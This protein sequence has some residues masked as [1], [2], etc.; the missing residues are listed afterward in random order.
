MDQMEVLAAAR[1]LRRDFSRHPEI[2]V[3]TDWILGGGRP[4]LV[5]AVSEVRE[6]IKE[7]IIEVG[8]GECLVC[9]ARREKERLRVNAA[10]KRLRDKRRRAEGKE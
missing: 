3:V 9:K 1:K 10:V 7:K 2:L 8:A 4:L 6:V 5:P